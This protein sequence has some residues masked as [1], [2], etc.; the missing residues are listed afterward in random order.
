MPANS[1][2]EDAEAK[3]ALLSCKSPNYIESLCISGQGQ[4]RTL[5]TLYQVETCEC[6]IV[7]HTSFSFTEKR[8]GPEVE[9]F[10][11]LKWPEGIRRGAS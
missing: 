1:P 11:T 9:S 8:G 10:L 2:R 6:G 7:V 5:K 4:N 3:S